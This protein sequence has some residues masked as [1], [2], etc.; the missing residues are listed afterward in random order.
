MPAVVLLTSI[1]INGGCN[2]KTI[3]IVSE[4]ELSEDSQKKLS[5]V[6]KVTNMTIHFKTLNQ[7]NVWKTKNVEF[8]RSYWSMALYLRLFLANTLPERVE[9]T[10]YLDGDTIV[11]R[12]L[13]PLWNIDISDY[14]IAGVRDANQFSKNVVGTS[15]YD[16][17]KYGYINSGVMLMNLR[18]IRENNIVNR[19]TDY[20]VEKDF[21]LPLHDQQ[22]INNILFDKKLLLPTK[23]NA[24]YDNYIKPKF[25]IT[26][27]EENNISEMLRDPVIVHYTWHIKPWLKY[28]RHP[29]AKEFTR[30][31]E[32]TIYKNEKLK[33]SPTICLRD[34]IAYLLYVIH[35]NY[36][37]R[38]F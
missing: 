5:D 20:I 29:L 17:H 34:K 30:I 8:K 36:K 21:V 13:E 9:K 31:K 27:I 26:S 6:C 1:G 10:I 4:N 19:F 14:A 2:S 3:Y 7:K 37:L 33:D 38:N 15:E 18:Y 28:C 25:R 16:I 12:S 22:V 32:K 23:F 11:R 35:L 24:Q